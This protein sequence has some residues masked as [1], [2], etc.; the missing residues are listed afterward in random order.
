MNIDTISFG[1]S[2]SNTDISSTKVETGS[3]SWGLGD[4]RTETDVFDLS[5]FGFEEKVTED[6]KL[7]LHA[8]EAWLAYK[9]I[10]FWPF[11]FF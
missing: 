8:M 5:F 7:S 10:L 6:H 4:I 11:V 2:A 1:L 9:F 3:S